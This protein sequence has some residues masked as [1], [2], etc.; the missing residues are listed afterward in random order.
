MNGFG[1][2]LG[3]DDMTFAFEFIDH[4]KDRKIT[5]DEFQ[6]ICKRLNVNGNPDDLFTA[7]DEQKSQSVKLG[8]FKSAI[9]QRNDKLMDFWNKLLTSKGLEQGAMDGDM[10][11]SEA[12]KILTNLKNKEDQRLKAMY[13]ITR[14]FCSL[15]KWDNPEKF[16]KDF[17]KSIGP[18][19]NQLKDR[20]TAIIRECC[21]CFAKIIM[22]RTSG[23]KSCAQRTM[24]NFIEV[25]KLQDTKTHRS[26]E[27][28]AATLIKYVPDRSAC[29][30]MK[31][32][33]DGCC[34]K[35]FTLLRQSCFGYV[36]YYLYTM[37]K[38]FEDKKKVFWDLLEKALKSGMG[39]SDPTVRDLA[40]SA[41]VKVELLKKD[42]AEK[43]IKTLKKT[44]K[45]KYD[46][47]KKEELVKIKS[48]DY[49]ITNG[50]SKGK[51]ET[52]SPKSPKGGKKKKSEKNKTY[53]INKRP[54]DD[55]SDDEKAQA[56]KKKKE[57]EEKAK[58]EKEAKEKAEKEKL[59]RER[60]QKEEEERKKQ[61]K[62][63]REKAERERFAAKKKEDRLEDERRRQSLKARQEK[64]QLLKEQEKLKQ[65]RLEREKQAK[66]KKEEEEK[67]KQEQQQKE[68]VANGG[69]GGG[70]GNDYGYPKVHAAMTA[71]FED[72]GVKCDNKGHL[73][74]YAKKKAIDGVTYANVNKYFKAQ[75]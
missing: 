22:A 73:V 37:I 25:I 41:L 52:K 3:D 26:G 60:K 6:L 74:L 36:N 45:E 57:E 9:E 5:L 49:S 69:G 40:Y 67:K 24:E 54:K 68:Q 12:N 43:Y 71:Y 61:E 33:T 17:K 13:S 50:G 27:Q 51:Q 46:S 72:K 58:R 63:D 15:K 32:I 14:K 18:L 16:E 59:E 19:L 44:R 4:K 38:E 35:N 11:I 8:A 28:A 55:I 42:L 2:L 53:K 34:E 70:D 75:K 29:P 48:D 66:L 30:I 23:Y 21:I 39:D 65:E 47:I 20:N 1:E 64:E 62:L 7:L 10:E 56:Q 31:L